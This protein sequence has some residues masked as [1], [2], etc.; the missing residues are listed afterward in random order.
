MDF[1]L[2]ELGVV[3]GGLDGL[4]GL[5]EE[6]HVQLFELGTCQGVG[7]VLT[8]AESFDFDTGLM[9]LR[10]SALGSLRFTAELLDG[11]LVL[12][13]VEAGLLLEL[14]QEILH[15]TLIEIFSSQVSVSGGGQHLEH[16]RVDGQDGNVKGSTSQIVNHNVLFLVFLIE[17]VSDGGSS[18]LV[19]NSQHIQPG[20]GTSIFGGLTLSVVEVSRDGDDGGLDGLTNVRLG[21]ILH[22][23]EDHGGDLLRGKN[24][25][26]SLD[27]DPDVGLSVLVNDLEGQQLH[28]RLD[29]GVSEVTTDQTLDVEEGVLRIEGG[30]VLGSLTDQTFLVIEGNI[31]GGDAVSEV[32][33]DD[34][35]TT[36]LENTDTGEGGPQIDTYHSSILTLGFII[37]LGENNGGQKAQ[38]KQKAELLHLFCV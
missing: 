6:I 38:T 34:L 33:G 23:G 8:L 11:L 31:R 36:L 27:L 35:D 32:V 29:S 21:N 28:V 17:S 5:L 4:Q 16:T 1:P 24:L 37:I 22:L 2:G 9:L 19:D 13:A 30:L 25:V 10:Q 12:G 20:D 15:D 18:G 3:E 14:L 7:K 26:L